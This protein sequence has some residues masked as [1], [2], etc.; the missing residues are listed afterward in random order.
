MTDDT[1]SDGHGPDVSPPDSSIVYENDEGVR[2]SEAVVRAVA[3]VTNTAV[4]D[5]DPLYDVIDP[6]HLDGICNR[7]DHSNAREERSITFRFNGCLVTVNQQTVHVQTAV[8]R[9]TDG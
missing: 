7:T 4:L 6:D 1:S 5:L 8:D 9:A 2:P 3:S